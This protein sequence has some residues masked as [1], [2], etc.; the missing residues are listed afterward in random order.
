MLD[1]RHCPVGSVCTGMIARGESVET[2][3]VIFLG[4]DDGRWV[5][6]GIDGGH[7]HWHEVPEVDPPT[8]SAAIPSRTSR[9]EPRSSVAEAPTFALPRLPLTGPFSF[10]SVKGEGAYG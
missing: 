2:A 1:L 9:P 3:S 6:F 5:R 7:F 8:E 10:C 4:I